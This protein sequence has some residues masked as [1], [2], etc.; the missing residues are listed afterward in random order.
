MRVNCVWRNGRICRGDNWSVL[1]PSGHFH[2]S[3]LAPVSVAIQ[4]HRKKNQ[5]PRGEERGEQLLSKQKYLPALLFSQKPGAT[6]RRQEELKE[7]EEA[8]WVVG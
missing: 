2:I 6:P 3:N 1:E 8:E 7:M 5:K 4:P